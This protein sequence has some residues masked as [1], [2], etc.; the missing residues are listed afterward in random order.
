M[1]LSEL[2][3]IMNNIHH[4]SDEFR[5]EL[6][7]NLCYLATFGLYDPLINDIDK[8]VQLIRYG[9]TSQYYDSYDNN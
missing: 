1:A 9:H 6:E 2:N 5:Y 7:S 8:S 3:E 4:E